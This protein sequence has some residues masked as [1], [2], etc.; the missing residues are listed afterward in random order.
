MA[1]DRGFDQFQ[2]GD[3][4]YDLGNGAARQ[5]V[6][7]TGG[8]L[9]E[10]PN[11]DEI[12]Q[13]LFEG[14]GATEK[15]FRANADRLGQSL[16]AESVRQVGRIIEGSGITRG[17]N[18]RNIEG[19]ERTNFRRL[20]IGAGV[21]NWMFRRAQLAA[22]LLDGDYH[23]DGAVLLGSGREMATP[24]EV[25]VDWVMDWREDHNGAN[26]REQDYMH[27]GVRP[28]LESRGVSVEEVYDDDPKAGFKKLVKEAKD[29]LDGGEVMLS[30]NAPASSTFGD[31]RGVVPDEALYFAADG[32]ALASSPAQETD[33]LHY[34]KVL[35]A[36]SALARWVKAVH[37]VNTTNR[38]N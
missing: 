28:L 5:L 33:S 1:L 22:G 23:F 9:G 10:D 13:Q 18:P 34:Q 3:N 8:E 25:D 14:W 24:T 17:I 11:S 19:N 30:Q 7:L 2:P 36:P 29:L 4:P 37:E 15:A 32:I 12:Q 16:D 35:S 6:E 38:S 21:Y 20:L 27:Y 31:V 26:P